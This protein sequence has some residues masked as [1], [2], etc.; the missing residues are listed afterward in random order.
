MKRLFTYLLLISLMGFSSCSYDDTS[1]WAKVNNHENRIAELE[2]L[3]K[4]MNSNISAMQTLVNALNEN[5][6]ITSVSPV[7]E[8]GQTIGYTISFTKSEPITIYHGKDGI[9]SESPVIGIKE[10]SDGVYY[11]TLND[12]WLVDSNGEMVMVEGIDGITPVFKIM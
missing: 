12:E 10:H 2:E 9:D 11:W 4:Q 1:L 7:V 8:N 5:N 3:C 6:Y